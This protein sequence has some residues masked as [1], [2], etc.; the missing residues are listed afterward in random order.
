MIAIN[1]YV[2]EIV[3]WFKRKVTRNKEMVPG[4]KSKSLMG[5]VAF[6]EVYRLGPLVK[7]GLPRYP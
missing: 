3:L 7:L 2:Y 4:N 1:V 6:V 5:D